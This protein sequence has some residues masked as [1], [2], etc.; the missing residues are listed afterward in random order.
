METKLYIFFEDKFLP[1]EHLGRICQ[2]P[3][4]FQITQAAHIIYL[5]TAFVFRTKLNLGKCDFPVAVPKI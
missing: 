4:I 2:S 1:E 3:C 5:T